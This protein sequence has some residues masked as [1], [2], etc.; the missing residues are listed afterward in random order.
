LFK[1]KGA[2]P[3]DKLSYRAYEAPLQRVLR[4]DV[5]V[6]DYE[7]VGLL[8]GKEKKRLLRVEQRSEKIDGVQPP[9][10]VSWLD[11]EFMPLRSQMEIPGIG[12]VTLY[13]ATRAAALAP[14]D[15]VP[16]DLGLDNFVRLKAPIEAPYEKQHVVYRVTVKGDDDPITTFARNRRQ[17]V[18]NVSGQSF[19]LDVRSARGPQEG[20]ADKKPGDEFTQSSY[21]ITSADP[22]VKAHAR[23]AVGDETDPWQKALRIEQWVSKH[24]K[25]QSN[26]AL[27]P[28]DQVAQTLQGDCTE[29]AMLTAAMCRAEG[30]A[31]RTAVG[32]IYADTDKQGPVFAFHMWTEVWVQGQWVPIDATLG[33]GYVGATH[34]KITDHSWHDVRAMTP[35]LPVLRVLGKVSIEVV[36]TG[37]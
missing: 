25:S 28:A 31:S 29:Y 20:V 30:V 7:D 16:L 6:R 2:K 19:E 32:L 24:M 3:G 36:E 11:K 34:L 37:G 13:R 9:T 8:G 21:F 35:L 15:R 27:A 26:E 33:R 14:A 18:K 23:A 17:R 1:Q 5:L 12:L 22:K 10:L 4:T